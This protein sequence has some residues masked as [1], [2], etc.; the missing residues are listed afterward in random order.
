M[1]DTLLRFPEFMAQARAAALANDDQRLWLCL[2]EAL[3]FR[4][5]NPGTWRAC[6]AGATIAEG[7]ARATRL[8]AGAV[9]LASA[10]SAMFDERS[11]RLPREFNPGR[12]AEDYLTFGYGQHWCIGAYIAMAQIT[13]TFKALLAKDGLRPAS[14]SD[15]RLR[16]ITIYPAYL[17]V[18]FNP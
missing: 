8:P 12:P 9:V 17:A 6:P 1:V 11:V 2:Q 18:E 5:I 4:F 15:G 16:R 3:R 14:G 13:A 7:T 10:Q